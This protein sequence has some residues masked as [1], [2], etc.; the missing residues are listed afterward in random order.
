MSNVF[1]SP[2]RGI[3]STSWIDRRGFVIGAGV[4]GAALG[5]GLGVVLGQVRNG[6]DR[7]L[8]IAPLKLELA[9][10]KIIET[11]AYNGTVP[12]PLLRFREGQPVTIDVTNDTDIEDIVHWHGLYL[13]SLFDGAMEEGSPMIQPAIPVGTIKKF[14]LQ[15]A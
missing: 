10:N 1:G 9:P 13:P 6:A 12:G 14:C 8:R 4:T 3:E 2:L 7:T 5:T 15:P 11:F